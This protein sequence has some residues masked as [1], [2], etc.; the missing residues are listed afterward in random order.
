MEA[1]MYISLW[2]LTAGLLVW[3]MV[4]SGRERELRDISN[5]QIDRDVT[6]FLRQFPAVPGWDAPAKTPPP[7]ENRWRRILCYWIIGAWAGVAA[8]A[9]FLGLSAANYH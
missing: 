6:E 7:V 8:L 2:G 9:L 1:Q 5:R 4:Q 3:G